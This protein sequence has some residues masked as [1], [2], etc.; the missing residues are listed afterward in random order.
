MKKH[1]EK[2]RKDLWQGYCARKRKG[3]EN[4][5]EVV[6]EEVVEGKVV[7]VSSSS[8]QESDSYLSFHFTQNPSPPYASHTSP[9]SALDI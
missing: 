3:K 6:Q 8:S 9:P 5:L 4:T 2:S 1:Q 7:D